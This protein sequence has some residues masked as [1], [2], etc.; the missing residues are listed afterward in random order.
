[1]KRAVDRTGPVRGIELMGEDADAR[2]QIVDSGR[3]KVAE[4][5]FKRNAAGFGCIPKRS[6]IIEPCVEPCPVFAQFLKTT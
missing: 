3:A 2:D 6:P 5:G 1:M 4:R